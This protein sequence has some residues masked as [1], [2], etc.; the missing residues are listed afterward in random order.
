[1]NASKVFLFCSLFV[2]SAAS[3]SSG[4]ETKPQ[5]NIPLTQVPAQVLDTANAAE[6]GAT[7]T[8]AVRQP[9]RTATNRFVYTLHGSKVVRPK[10]T[11][12]LGDG[13]VDIIPAETV[14]LELQAQ[15]DGQLVFIAKS[16]R[17]EEVPDGVLRALKKS[18]ELEPSLA[19]AIRT[20][21]NGPAAAYMISI[22]MKGLLRYVVTADGKQ[23]KKV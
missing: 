2:I 13:D 6:P 10:Q 1:M 17:L 7:W 20:T 18:T 4:E 8:T 21:Q 23:V 15:A 11:R 14:T 9:D 5:E 22:D 19:W 16:I 12:V 3:R